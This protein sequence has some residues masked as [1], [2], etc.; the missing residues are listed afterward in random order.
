[1]DTQKLQLSTGMDAIATIVAIAKNLSLTTLTYKIYK[2]DKNLSEEVDPAKKNS[3][4]RM[5]H[6]QDDER[7]DCKTFARHEIN[8]QTLREKCNVLEDGY[9]LGIMSNVKEY[10]G[11]D[12]QIPMMDFECDANDEHKARVIYFLAKLD[13]HGALL[14]SGRSYHFYGSKLL[15]DHEWRKFLGQCLLFKGFTDSRYIGHRL[16]NGSCALRVSS[17]KLRPNIPTCVAV[18]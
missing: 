17:G 1:M 16:I 2:P 8:V 7:E 9:Y 12:R 6:S 14:E 15:S 4:D 10:K 3:V 13:L 11:D 5:L 18:F